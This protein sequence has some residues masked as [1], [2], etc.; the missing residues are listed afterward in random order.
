MTTTPISA[1]TTAR[2]R[3]AIVIAA[4]AAMLAAFVYHPHVGNPIDADFLAKLAAAV[5]A[6]TTRWAF[7]HLAAAAGSGL[8]ILAF[9][10]VRSRL[11]EAGEERWSVLGLPFIV[12]GSVLY[13]VLPGMEFAPLAAAETGA[14]AAAAQGAVMPWFVPVLL[15]SAVTFA[16]GALAFAL[17]IARSG[18]LSPRLTGLVVGALVVMAAARFVPINMVQFYVQSGAAIVALWPLAYEMWN[19]PQA[20][21]AGR[22]RRPPAA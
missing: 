11:R 16:L 15:T 7:S 6:D 13:A 9:L 18:V 1:T 12:M 10:A 8:L 21:F 4:P 2:F 17:A 20:Q 14:D 19:R 22:L 3:A 5:S